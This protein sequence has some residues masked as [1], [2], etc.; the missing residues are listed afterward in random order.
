[1]LIKKQLLAILRYL[2]HADNFHA[3]YDMRH[4]RMTEYAEYT[5]FDCHN[6]PT[7]LMSRNC[8]NRYYGAAGPCCKV[9]DALNFISNV[10]TELFSHTKF[11]LHGD[12]DMYW[13]PDQV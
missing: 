8:D 2:N 9:D 5:T 6:E 4:C 3:R 7:Y 10:R 13:R 11:I 12:D 1:M